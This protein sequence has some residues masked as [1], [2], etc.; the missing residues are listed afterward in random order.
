[1]KASGIFVR[2]SSGIERKFAPSPATFYSEK[3]IPKGQQFESFCFI[4][5]WGIQSIRITGGGEIA[6]VPDNSNKLAS[7]ITT[8]QIAVTHER[9]DPKIVGVSTDLSAPNPRAKPGSIKEYWH[10]VVNPKTHRGVTFRDLQGN[11]LRIV[12][13]W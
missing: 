3:H 5:P 12:I 13:E 7:L 10:T 8:H 6:L 4:D 1:M 2:A 9:K 11:Q